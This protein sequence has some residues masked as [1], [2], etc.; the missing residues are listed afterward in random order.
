M[1]CIYCGVAEQ[2]NDHSC[3]SCGSPK[4]QS[5]E[6]LAWPKRLPRDQAEKAQL[7]A[8]RLRNEVRLQ[9]HRLRETE[10]KAEETNT[11]VFGYFMLVLLILAP[12]LIGWFQTLMLMRIPF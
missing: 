2:T 3:V 9:I 12:F 11:R 8:E 10:T 6:G 7:E 5:P 4:A 1:R